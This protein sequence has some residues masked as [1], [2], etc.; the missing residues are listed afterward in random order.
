VAATDIEQLSSD[1]HFVREAVET[2]TKPNPLETRLVYGYW[3]LYV[4]IG[5]TLIDVSEAAAGVFFMI[6]GFAGGIVSWA[7]GKHVTKKYGQ[8]ARADDNRRA[9]LHWACGI[10]LSVIGAG[11]LAMVIPELRGPAGSQ[12]LLMM[13]GLVYFFW[14]VWFDRNFLWLGPVLML[15]AIAVSFI[16]VR[17]WTSVGIVIAL[18][19]VIPTLFSKVPARPQGEAAAS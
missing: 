5:Y 6:G 19:L 7:I 16:P 8:V 13:I 10:I 14:G 1:L 9:T 2:R 4:L 18:G 15:G 12:V 11:A 17:P 3:A